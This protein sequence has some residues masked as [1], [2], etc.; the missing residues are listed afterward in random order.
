MAVLVVRMSRAVLLAKMPDS[1]AASALQAFTTKLQSMVAP[2]L[3]QSMTYDQGCEMSRHADLT[4]ATGV[5]VY[6]HS[7][8]PL[9]PTT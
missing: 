9:Q 4:A 3:R 6:C 8:A 5:R 2:L 7:L 1:T